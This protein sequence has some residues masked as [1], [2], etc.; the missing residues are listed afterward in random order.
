MAA[1][2]HNL[3]EAWD[4]RPDD[5]QITERPVPPEVGKHFFGDDYSDLEWPEFFGPPDKS[6]LD[7]NGSCS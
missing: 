5:E 3:F 1:P 4:S 6:K 7:G 2:I